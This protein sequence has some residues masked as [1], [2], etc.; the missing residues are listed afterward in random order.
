MVL[1]HL[2]S[3]PNSECICFDVFNLGFTV[4]ICF[5]DEMS[6]LNPKLSS[7]DSVSLGDGKLKER[8]LL[9]NGKRP[10]HREPEYFNSFSG[11]C[12]LSV[13]Y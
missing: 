12:D 1:P 3:E 2:N 4:I 13:L 5:N 6:K 7:K 11:I 9:G 8:Y 10:T